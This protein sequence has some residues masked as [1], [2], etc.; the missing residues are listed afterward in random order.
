MKRS[1]LVMAC[2]VALI[3]ASYAGEAPAVSPP[4]DIALAA[5]VVAQ[6][7]APADPVPMKFREGLTR[8]QRREMGL[9][10]R[11]VRTVL[12]GLQES[13]E[14]TEDMTTSEVSLII[15]SYLLDANPHAFQDLEGDRDWD[16]FL[17][18]LERLIELLMKFMVLFSS[19]DL[20]ET[21]L[22]VCQFDAYGSSSVEVWH[23]E[24]CNLA[25]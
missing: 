21:E 16:S 10:F 18:F 24:P 1:I 14:I 11:N 7:V 6:D 19:I 22:Q 15:A 5:A 20:P 2:G 4:A 25:A 3:L 12:A 13:G 8:K 17:A 23:F 9:T